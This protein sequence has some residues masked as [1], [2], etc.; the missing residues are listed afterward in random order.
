VFL[1]DTPI[2][3]LR[4]PCVPGCA[5]TIYWSYDSGEPMTRHYPG[6]PD[7]FTPETGCLNSHLDEML[8]IVNLRRVEGELYRQLTQ[9]EI[10]L[11][12]ARRSKHSS[13]TYLGVRPR[14]LTNP[15]GYS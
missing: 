7:F 1:D 5:S 2:S 8:D 3:A 9:W 6:S 14:S 12:G 11:D 4:T 15:R 10:I 13:C